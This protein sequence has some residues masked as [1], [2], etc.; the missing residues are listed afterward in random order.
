MS[1]DP[2]AAMV[3]LAF[4]KA[5]TDGL[6]ITDAADIV[7][8]VIRAKQT[9]AEL[10]GIQ[11][12]PDVIAVQS[13]VGARTGDPYVQCRIGLE[14]WQWDID[15]ARHHAMAV[16]TC[17]EAAVHDA[18]MI[19]WMTLGEMDAPPEVAWQAVADLRRFRGD[20]D[21]ADWRPSEQGAT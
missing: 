4:K 13:I 6:S 12:S 10:E 15:T 21:R 1:R 17:A 19:R 5:R 3:E 9:E 18:A 8:Q 16:L 2:L 20:V 7:A 14:Q 11:P